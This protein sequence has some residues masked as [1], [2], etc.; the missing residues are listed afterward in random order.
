MKTGIARMRRKKTVRR[1]RF[2]SSS[3]IRPIGWWGAALLTGGASDI[4]CLL[5]LEAAP[6]GEGRV[7]AGEQEQVRVRQRLV[8]HAVLHQVAHSS[9]HAPE[10]DRREPAD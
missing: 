10:R 1:E 7:T 9:G 6:A 2:R 5:E 8:A 4:V 3:T